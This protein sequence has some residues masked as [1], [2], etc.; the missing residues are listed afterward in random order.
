M[1]NP[2]IFFTLCVQLW[3]T[4]YNY[5]G[6]TSPT[7]AQFTISLLPGIDYDIDF[8]STVTGNLIGI[9]SMVASLSNGDL[10]VPLIGN[11]DCDANSDFAYRVVKHGV[12]LRSLPTESNSK[13]IEDFSFTIQPNPNA[14]IFNLILPLIAVDKI[15]IR[16]ANNSGQIIFSELLPFEQLYSLNLSSY[17]KGIYNIIISAGNKISCRRFINQ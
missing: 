15:T 13:K 11:L 4:I 5:Y 16:V 1:K 3:L 2:L 9:Q 6:C 8:Y 10:I 12:V 14:G 7:A 17:P